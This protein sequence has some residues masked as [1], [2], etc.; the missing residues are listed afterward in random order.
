MGGGG[1]HLVLVVATIVVSKIE[2]RPK[3]NTIVQW[4]SVNRGKDGTRTLRV[5]GREEQKESN[6]SSLAP[7]GGRE[8]PRVEVRR[9]VSILSALGGSQR[10][11][12]EPHSGDRWLRHCIRP[13]VTTRWAG[14]ASFLFTVV[15]EA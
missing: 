4:F 1:D 5:C 8:R 2:H 6:A 7:P 14:S 10:K 3:I 11:R 9:Q 15:Q 12:I 13:Q